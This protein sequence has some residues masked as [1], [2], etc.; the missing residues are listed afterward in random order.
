[1][2][3]SSLI[4]PEDLR[5][6]ERQVSEPCSSQELLDSSHCAQM[7]SFLT[8]TFFAKETCDCESL[9]LVSGTEESR[10]LPQTQE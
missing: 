4:Q 6:A 8:N 5:D 10:I 9:N 1:M 7:I 2:P 3:F